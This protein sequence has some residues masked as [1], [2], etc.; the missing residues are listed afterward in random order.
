ME[1]RFSV[2]QFILSFFFRSGVACLCYPAR[3]YPRFDFDTDSRGMGP[4][5]VVALL[6]VT[7]T[8]KMFAPKMP[9]ISK[10]R[11]ATER[12][13]KSPRTN[14]IWSNKIKIMLAMNEE[15]KKKKQTKEIK[16]TAKLLDF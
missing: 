5:V 4:N 1:C 16:P 3:Q 13:N 12:P 8:K 7:K 14:M 9:C 11:N 2:F 6:E 10:Q 15:A